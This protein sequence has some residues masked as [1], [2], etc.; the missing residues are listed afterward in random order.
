M[1][2]RQLLVMP[3]N[4]LAQR[5]RSGGMRVAFATE[6]RR[7]AKDFAQFQE[8]LAVGFEEGH[9][10]VSVH[11]KRCCR[12]AFDVQLLHAL[13]IGGLRDGQAIDLELV[14]IRGTHSHRMPLECYR[15]L[16]LRGGDYDGGRSFC[17]CSLLLLV[18]AAAVVVCI[19]V[20]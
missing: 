15:R 11:D 8:L 12:S 14:R 5:Q 4:V 6:L 20:H 2:P 16:H 10:K 18:G 7:T 1:N 3:S 17:C 19:T 9:Q 13:E